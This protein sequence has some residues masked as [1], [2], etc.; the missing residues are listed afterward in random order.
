M[1]IAPTVRIL[2]MGTPDFAVPI[3]RSLH[4]RAAENGWQVVAV[5]SQPD[6]PAGRGGKVVA[7]PLKELAISLG[8]AR[9]PACQLTQIP[10]PPW[11]KFATWRLI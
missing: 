9:D 4:E 10:P 6:R 8:L 1:S 3:L 5:A 11:K 7:G 2:F